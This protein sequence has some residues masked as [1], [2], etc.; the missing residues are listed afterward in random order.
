MH[1][2]PSFAFEVPLIWNVKGLF[3]GH[4]VD[5]RNGTYFALWPKSIFNN[6]SEVFIL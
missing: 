6:L 2:T 4:L 5:V 3:H 1:L